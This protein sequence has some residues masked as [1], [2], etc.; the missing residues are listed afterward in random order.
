MMHYNPFKM[1]LIPLMQMNV[2]LCDLS[3]PDSFLVCVIFSEWE[4]CLTVAQCWNRQ[5]LVDKK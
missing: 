1:P 4:M 5:C 3:L 2:P